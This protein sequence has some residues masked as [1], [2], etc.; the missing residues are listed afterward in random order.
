MWQ[1][2]SF[3]YKFITY[4]TVDTWHK[5]TVYDIR[6]EHVK[7]RNYICI[8]MTATTNNKNFDKQQRQRLPVYIYYIYTYP[9]MYIASRE[10]EICCFRVKDIHVC[11]LLLYIRPSG[12][13]VLNLYVLA[14][15]IYIV[16]FV[17]LSIAHTMAAMQFLY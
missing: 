7:Q 17:C 6:E 2:T 1:N 14:A 15:R 9:D 3:A 10:S 12:R 16:L 13:I 4:K 5:K 8:A 11:F